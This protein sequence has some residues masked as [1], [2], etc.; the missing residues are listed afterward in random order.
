MLQPLSVL[1]VLSVQSVFKAS[2][3][4]E[5]LRPYLLSCGFKVSKESRSQGVSQPLTVLSVLSV[6]SVFEVSF[7]PELLRQYLPIRGLK[8]LRSQGVKECCS[9]RVIRVIRVR[10]LPSSQTP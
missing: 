7:P 3:P 2:F 1:S 10:K 8:P 4:P 9:I 5:L 6:Q